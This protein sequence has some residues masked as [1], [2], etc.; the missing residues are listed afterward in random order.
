MISQPNNLDSPL[1]TVKRKKC[2]FY[3]QDK[4]KQIW[5]LIC[6]I[7]LIVSC[8]TIPFYLAIY[9][10][11]DE[12]VSSIYIN[13]IVDCCFFLDI[14]VTFNTA[15]H[16]SQ[17]KIVEDRKQIAKMYLKKWF[18]IDLLV[19]LPYDQIISLYNPSFQN[20]VALSKFVRIMKIVRLVRLL[21]LIKVAKDRKKMAAILASS[22]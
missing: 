16:V 20:V 9:F 3:P 11:E 18:W 22:L 8:L 15:V 12:K 5:D 6:G 13:A 7:C 14:L 4:L 21:K 19:T 17:V 2:L 10:D 1:P